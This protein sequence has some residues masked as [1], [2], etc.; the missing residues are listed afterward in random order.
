VSPDPPPY[1]TTVLTGNLQVILNVTDGF[2]TTATPLS[3]GGVEGAAYGEVIGILS[4]VLELSA[5]TFEILEGGTV[6]DL[7]GG[8]Q[9]PVTLTVDPGTIW[10]YQSLDPAHLTVDPN[11]ADENQIETRDVTTFAMSGEI[12]LLG[13]LI[14]FSFTRTG[15]N[16]TNGLPKIV[17][18]VIAIPHAV[19]PSVALSEFSLLASL[20]SRNLQTRGDLCAYDFA[21][22]GG[23]TLTL[24]THLNF[25]SSEIHY[26]PEPSGLPGLASG[27]ALLMLLALSKLRGV[28][29][30]H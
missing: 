3:M 10:E 25:V 17:D 5:L 13:E 14:P 26:V 24:C 7:L 23:L 27:V 9:I 22:V 20:P 29:L 21:E 1:S 28:S 12:D 19:A 8:A 6:T 2:T 18:S 11:L 4:P 16:F 30:V 15:V